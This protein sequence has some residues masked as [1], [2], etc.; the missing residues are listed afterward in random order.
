MSPRERLIIALDLASVDDART[1]VA[2]IGEAG[3][4]YKVGMELVYAGGLPLVEVMGHPLAGWGAVQKAALDYGLDQADFLAVID[5]MEMDV[6]ADIRAPAW[7]ELDIYCDMDSIS[8]TRSI[9][10]RGD[11][12]TFLP[13]ACVRDDLKSGGAYI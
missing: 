12:A 5:G 6:V 2:R 13:V 9:V 1:L 11:A 10:A 7:A 3:A 4:F 8:R